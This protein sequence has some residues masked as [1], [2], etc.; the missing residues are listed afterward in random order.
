MAGP[1]FEQKLHSHWDSGVPDAVCV[2]L[3]KQSLS[4]ETEKDPG[5]E[6]TLRK[7]DIQ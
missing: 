4:W 6:L 2:W 1:P 5:Q 3:A 7:G